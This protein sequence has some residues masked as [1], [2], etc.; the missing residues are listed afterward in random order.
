MPIR[1][2]HQLTARALVPRIERLFDLSA[3]KILALERTWEPAR[4]TPVVTVKGQYTSR[5]WTEWTQGFQVGSAVLQFDATG[6]QRFLEIGRRKTVQLMAPH[7]SHM[8]VHDHGFNNISTYGNLWRLMREGK[9]PFNE[10]ERDFYELAL[11]ISGAVQAARWSRTADGGGFIYSFNGPHSL[12]VDTV[13]S[14][15]SL[16]VA[17]QLG[18]V[19]RGERD[20]SISLLERLLTHGETTALYSVYYGKGRDAFDVRGRTAHESIFNPNDGSYRCPNSQQGYSAFSTWT[21]GLAWAILGFAEQLE[22][23][24]ALNGKTTARA[25]QKPRGGRAKPPP[26]ARDLTA[27]LALFLDAAG[28]TAEF[29]LANTC[30]DG[31]PMWD[32]G[33]PNL[34]RLGDYLAKPAD[35]FNRWE[36]VDSSAAA[37]AAQGLVRLGHYVSGRGDHKNGERY[38]QAG[39]TVAKTLFDE[40]YL[41]RD[42]RHQGLLLHSVYHRP[43]GWDCV[44]RGQKVPNGESSMWGDYHARELAL[45]LLREARCEKYPTFFAA[46]A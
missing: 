5:A 24:G 8:G 31:I 1:I 9:I 22:F 35:P 7:V 38:H 18:H 36:P 43:N 26:L 25:V 33:A 23:L 28:A 3:Q 4:G 34:H 15:R 20:R 39:L 29:Y 21:R 32:T 16:A 46:D 2:D 10:R 11:K 37:I 19:L 13:R 14:L 6:E 45:L 30:A 12:F 42:P 27:T 41:S 17:H 44:A 40:P